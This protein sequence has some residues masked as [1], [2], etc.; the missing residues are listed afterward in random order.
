MFTMT[1][2]TREAVYSSHCRSMGIGASYTTQ[3]RR[4]LRLN[5]LKCISSFQQRTGAHITT[6]FTRLTVNKIV[7]EENQRYG[8]HGRS[9][10]HTVEQ[11]VTCSYVHQSPAMPSRRACRLQLSHQGST[12]VTGTRTRCVK[13]AGASTR[14]KFQPT[15]NTD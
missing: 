4:G 15:N 12:R 2:H 8:Q 5:I 1:T 6:C 3:P 14:V 7:R 9:R 11:A 10:R 13:H